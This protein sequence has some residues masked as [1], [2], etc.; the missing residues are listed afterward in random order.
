MLEIHKEEKSLTITKGDGILTNRYTLSVDPSINTCKSEEADQKLVRH[1]IQCVSTGTKQVVVRTVDTDVLLLLL[2]FRHHVG[3]Y[4]CNVY[5]YFGTGK[6][7]CYYDINAIALRLGE[8]TCRALPFFHAFSGCDCVSSFFNQGKCKL[9]DRWQDYEDN[10]TLTH[11]FSELSSR[12][13]TITEEQLLVLEKFILFVYYP[14][15]IGPADLDTQR[16]RE[17]EFSTSNSLRLIPPSKSGLVQHIKRASY[18]AGWIAYQ[19]IQNIEL[20]DPKEWGWN[21]INGVYLPR[22]QENPN[23]I[24]ALIVTSTCSCVMSKCNKCICSKH[25]LQ[26]LTFCKCHRKCLYTAM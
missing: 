4:E 9:W 1:M 10:I 15:L 13:T 5:A 2:A 7:K 11:V 14:Q 25:N 23:P 12:P 16:M 26:C 21:F 17:F 8:D 19:C 18:E 20:P 3:H 22:W 6:S 24:D